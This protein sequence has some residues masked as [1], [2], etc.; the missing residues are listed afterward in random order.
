MEVHKYHFSPSHT[1]FKELHLSSIVAY[2]FEPP[3]HPCDRHKW[4]TPETLCT[5]L[6]KIDC[7]KYAKSTEK[8]NNSNCYRCSK[9]SS[10]TLILLALILP[11]LVIPVLVLSVLVLPVLVQAALKRLVQ[12]LISAGH[13]N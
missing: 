10:K 7:Q 6:K 4:A 11:V 12:S 8:L 9:T 3:S 2:F 13:L 5:F 1:P